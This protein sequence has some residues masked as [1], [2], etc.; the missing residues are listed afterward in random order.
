MV[1]NNAEMQQVN[2]CTRVKL[3][4]NGVKNTENHMWPSDSLDLEV[5]LNR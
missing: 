5:F 4:W 3:L 1:K 2:L